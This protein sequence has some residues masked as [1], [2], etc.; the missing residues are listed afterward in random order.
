MDATDS[1]H[2]FLDYF[3]PIHAAAHEHFQRAI[4]SCKS[5]KSISHSVVTN[6]LRPMD[7]SL[8]GSSVHRILQARILEW[9]AI[10]SCLSLCNPMDYIPP[11]YSVHRIL[12]ARILEWAAIPFFRGFSP[13]R[14][15]TWA[16]GI[17]GR[18]FTIWAISCCWVTKL[19]LTL[20][21]PTDYNTPGFPVFHYLLEFPQTH[22]YWVSHAIQS[23]HPLL[24]PL[25]LPSVFISI[26]VFSSELALRI[27][28]PK[29]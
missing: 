9:L 24:S 3:C 22:V 23:P 10:Q 20:C 16:S 8:P 5:N 19:C 7:C 29:Y 21:N 28:S 1:Q 11:G 17:A 15:Q 25:L 6:S 18:F 12:Q 13:P 27:S 26:R 2:D 14:D 4:W